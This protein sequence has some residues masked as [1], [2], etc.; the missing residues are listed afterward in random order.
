M[1]VEG[2]SGRAVTCVPESLMGAVAIGMLDSTAAKDWKDI[3][4]GGK[5]FEAS[6]LEAAEEDGL[7]ATREVPPALLTMPP[8]EIP[9][10]LGF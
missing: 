4:R 10:M 6:G 1:A 9:A 2:S 7:H 5:K 8:P 3:V